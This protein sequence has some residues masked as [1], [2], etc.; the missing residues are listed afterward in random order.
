MTSL[1]SAAMNRAVTAYNAVVTPTFLTNASAVALGTEQL[2]L[3]TEPESLGFAAKTLHLWDKSYHEKRIDTLAQFYIEKLKK[4]LEQHPR[5]PVPEALNDKL[6]YTDVRDFLRN[7]GNHYNK[8]PSIIELKKLHLAAK[9]GITP[10]V[11]DANEGFQEYAKN[12]LERYLVTY[13]HEIKVDNSN[14]ISLKFNGQ[15]TRWSEI[16]DAK[17]PRTPN[18]NK[19]LRFPWHYDITGV[20]WD[21]DFCIISDTLEPMFIRDPKEWDNIDLFEVWACRSVY[22]WL[23]VI[24][25]VHVAFRVYTSDG[26]VYS[27][28]VYRQGKLSGWDHVIFPLRMKQAFFAYEI[29]DFWPLAPEDI[30]SIKKQITPEQRDE[31]L[32]QF[33]VDAK[34]PDRYFHISQHNCVVYSAKLL[35]DIVGVTLPTA[36]SVYGL[37]NPKRFHWITNQIPRKI[38]EIC[39]AVGAIFINLLQIA[40]G[41]TMIDKKVKNKDLKPLISS[42]L[43]IFNPQKALGHHPFSIFTKTYD[44]VQN[45]RKKEEA[46]LKE[47]IAKNGPDKK[48]L[49]HQL[50]FLKYQ[51]PP[52]SELSSYY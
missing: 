48:E 51:L 2:E 42:P 41:A 25:G 49:E 8:L 38:R 10:E 3:K 44:W 32:K 23:G 39:V 52:E 43:D 45:W 33:M 50:K 18:P 26:K 15:F 11:M 36:Q 30:K 31:I 17:V 20:V 6:I 27:N 47:E 4:Y 5:R 35:R 24:T 19:D 29:S 34:D 21:K 22:S 14:V 13:G 37:L 12:S 1:Y 40:L 46:R 28:S 9:L 16:H 7:D